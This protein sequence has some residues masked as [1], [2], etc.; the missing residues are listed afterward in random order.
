MS[1]PAQFYTGLVAE[2]YEPLAG[3]ISGSERFARFVR[4]QG[5]AALELACGSGKPMLDLLA[6]GL[7]VEGLD[8]SADM[9]EQ[10]RQSA[11]RRGLEPTLHLG[12]MQSFSLGKRFSAI[13]IANGSITLLTSD[14]DLAGCL[15]AVHGHLEPEGAL[16][17]D[18]DM[19]D[20]DAMKLGL[21]RFRE[22][23]ADDGTLIRCGMIGLDRSRDDRNLTIRLRYERI[24]L[25]G[26]EE[27]LERDW[28][29]RLWSREM[30]EA[31]LR[32]AGFDVAKAKVHD[33]AVTFIATISGEK[34]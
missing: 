31:H 18:V 22:Q 26:T 33:D 5:G 11:A 14:A 1:D 4:R 7:P 16:L 30:F 8:A 2:L 28:Q 6:E 24:S 20:V 25:D 13:Y 19:P 23:T 27:V 32:A 9:L 34:P 17:V 15:A 21:N 12:N 10:C 29:R 3:G